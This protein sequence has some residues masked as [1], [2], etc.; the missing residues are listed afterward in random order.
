MSKKTDLRNQSVTRRTAITAITGLAAGLAGCT[1]VSTN[2]PD[3]A[4]PNRSPERTDDE[5]V[6]DSENFDVISFEDGEMVV[7][8]VDDADVQAVNL[9]AP[10]GETFSQ[11]QVEAGASTVTFDLITEG[12]STGEYTLVAVEHDESVEEVSIDLIPDVSIQEVYHARN[13]PNM[14]WD[15][16]RSYW[17]DYGVVKLTNDGTGPDGISEL[18]WED[19]PRTLGSRQGEIKSPSV[20]GGFV[21][22]IGPDESVMVY[23]DAAV[24]SGEFGDGPSECKEIDSQEFTVTAVLEIGDD[25]TWSEDLAYEWDDEENNCVISFVDRTEES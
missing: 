15:T 1:S 21:D 17:K 9:I 13:Q 6:S 5:S 3:T 12:Y 20:A 16:D 18:I 22:T 2:E 19:V 11:A 4:N 23:T 25:P 14:D 24:F 7:T 8:L 10:N